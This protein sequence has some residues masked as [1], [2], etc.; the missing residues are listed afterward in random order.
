MTQVTL[1]GNVTNEPKLSFT[2]KG[3]A[4]ASFTVAVNERVKK[5]DEWVD[6]E[7]TFYRVTAWRKIGE[8]A[9]EHIVKG[10]RV[11][12]LGKLKQTSYVNKEGEQRNSLDVSAD[13]VAKS[14][15]FLKLS[16]PLKDNQTA[17]EAVAEF[18]PPK[19]FED[20]PF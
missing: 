14:V 4:V 16:S 11:V 3:D 20:V 10:E 1:V 15:K 12:V 2:A 5:D 9:A 8:Q 13:E 6:G 17:R 19:H 7:A 18:F